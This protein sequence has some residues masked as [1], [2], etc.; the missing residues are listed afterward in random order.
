M[1]K[2]LLF[3]VLFVIV[4]AVVFA[5]LAPLLFGGGDFR[6]IGAAAFPVI[7]LVCGGLGFF[8]GLRRARK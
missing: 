6:K 2:G 7:L 3:A 1:L 4:G 5:F 8:V